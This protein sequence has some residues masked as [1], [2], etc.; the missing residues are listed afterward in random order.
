M[1]AELADIRSEFRQDSLELGQPLPLELFVS[2]VR[3]ELG[4]PE[5]FASESLE[6]CFPLREGRGAGS[7]ADRSDPPG[8]ALR[9][10]AVDSAV[11]AS[12][13]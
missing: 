11:H 3:G 7:N 13:T 9:Y 4:L 6:P 2:S 10:P 12:P 8:A 1:R 5:E